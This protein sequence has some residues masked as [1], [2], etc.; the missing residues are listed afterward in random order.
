MAWSD[1]GVEKGLT[2]LSALNEDEEYNEHYNVYLLS[3]Y[4]AII[5]LTSIGYGDIT[6]QS[7]LEFIVACLCCSMMAC[8]WAYVIGALCSIMS[9]MSEYELKFRS[10]MDDLNWL[11]SDRQM[12]PKLGEKFRRYFNETREADRQNTDKKLFQQMSPKLQGEFTNF[13]HGKW[14]RK[15]WFL[16]NMPDEVVVVISKSLYLEV[17][18]PNEE[19]SKYRTLFIIQ[20][21]LVACEPFVIL[22]SGDMWGA[23]MLLTNDSLR[24]QNLARTLS[25]VSVH[26]LHAEDLGNIFIDFPEARAVLRWAQVQ[27]AIVR[28]VQKIAMVT[29]M[30]EK[31][32]INL[33]EMSEE[34]RMDMF[35]DIMHGKYDEPQQLD[36]FGTGHSQRR[37]YTIRLE[38]AKPKS[39]NGLMKDPQGGDQDLSLPARVARLERTLES[40]GEKMDQVVLAT[41]GR[42]STAGREVR[43]PAAVTANF[44]PLRSRR[45]LRGFFNHGREPRRN[46]GVGGLE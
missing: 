13:M 4:W 39:G 19:V 46:G 11:I 42:Q 26:M 29:A 40:L 31:K 6:P 28:G 9:S 22:R 2:W 7:R 24:Q 33:A 17:F 5:S 45:F 38:D 37:G 12:P 27:I 20:R 36:V 3:L 14:I 41:T 18:A 21:G 15:V 43:H 8:I 32:G 23:D 16:K 30:M 35:S 1:E 34:K 10:T 44:G 25:Y